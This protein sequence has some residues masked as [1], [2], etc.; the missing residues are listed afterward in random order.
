MKKI[1]FLLIIFLSACTSEQDLLSL[2]YEC[3]ELS[4]EFYAGIP[5]CSSQESCF[6]DAKK[7]FFSFDYSFYPSEIKEKIFSLNN[8][9]S[10]SW[11]YYNKARKELNEIKT[12][13]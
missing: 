3:I 12:N 1:L 4:N 7:E 9:I 6:K 13:C 2:K 10:K 5:E 8:S 11:F